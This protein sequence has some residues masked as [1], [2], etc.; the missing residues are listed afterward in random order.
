MTI[1]IQ[2][3]TFTSENVVERINL[4]MRG[5]PGVMS[6]Y[7][8]VR[9]YT[10]VYANSKLIG[11]VFTHSV[12]DLIIEYL[13]QFEKTGMYP[14]RISDSLGSFAGYFIVGTE[15]IKFQGD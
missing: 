15:R 8:H 9:R 4:D 1:T 2:N 13:L 11:S 7:P 5:T 12:E 6:N 14:E 10:R 3:I